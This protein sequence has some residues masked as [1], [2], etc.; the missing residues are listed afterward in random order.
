VYIDYIL[1]LGGM[2]EIM[3]APLEAVLKSMNDSGLRTHPGKTTIFASGIE[4]LGFLLTE[5][6]MMLPATS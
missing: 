1:I 4:Y 6:D 5:D 3:M 2:E